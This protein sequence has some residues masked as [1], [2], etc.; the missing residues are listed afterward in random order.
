MG[1]RKIIK[2]QQLLAILFQAGRGGGI[3]ASVGFQEKIQSPLGVG[4]SLGRDNLSQLC[5]RAG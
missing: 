1:R 4:L 5:Q 3:V 2:C